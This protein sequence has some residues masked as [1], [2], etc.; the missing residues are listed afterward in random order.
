MSISL[1]GKKIRDL[2]Q[3][4]LVK[5]VLNADEPPAVKNQRLKYLEKA[6]N[7]DL[8]D[9]PDE[10]W[11]RI[12]LSQL[13]IEQLTITSTKI[14]I[15]PISNRMVGQGVVVKSIREL[16]TEQSK[17]LNSFLVRWES[18]NSKAKDYKDPSYS[19]D[20]KETKFKMLSESLF[21]D[22][23]FIQIPDGVKADEPITIEI[24]QPEKNSVIF[25]QIYIEAGK[26]SELN[27]MV[28]YKSEQDFQALSLGAVKTI[29]DDGAKM[30]LLNY[31]DFSKGIMSYHNENF[32]LK[33]SS[34]LTYNTITT[35]SASSMWESEAILLEKGSDATFNGILSLEGSQHAGNR[36]NVKH[37]SPYTNSNL[38]FNS[39][40]RDASNS[41]FIGKIKMPK[42]AQRCKGH[43]TNNNL[44]LGKQSKAITMPI[45]EIIAN[46][47][48]CSHGA[49][50]GSIDKNKIF[51]LTSRG[52]NENEAESI[53]TRAY[54]DDILNRM[55]IIKNN[56]SINKYIVNNLN[57]KLNIKIEEEIY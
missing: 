10:A 45:L 39:I 22:G 33:H 28:E 55:G 11:R 52:I 46:N 30:E 23:V 50:A 37:Y 7:T 32:I 15:K 18:L 13:D 51:Y 57:K 20:I 54:Y 47:V 40:L 25:P 43:Q 56:K 3:N 2:N 49:T 6:I 35:G 12:D 27:V 8:P 17:G 16:L 36:V 31:Q 9:A 14:N 4:G 42:I 24:I 1:V 5:T 19:S 26:Q 41:L 21:Q 34:K 53:I 48:E 29:L 38:L 44:I